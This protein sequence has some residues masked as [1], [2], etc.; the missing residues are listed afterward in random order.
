AR[1]DVDDLWLPAK[2]RTQLDYLKQNPQVALL[3]SAALRICDQGNLLPEPGRHPTTYQAIRLK[4]LLSNAFFHSS[5]LVNLNAL[6]EQKI[7]YD[8]AKT[9]AQDYDLWS[10]L[11]TQHQG[12]NLAQP[13]IKFRAYSGQLSTTAWEEQQSL[14]DVI[15]WENFQRMG[16][17]GRFTPSEVS[18]MRRTGVPPGQISPQDRLRQFRSLLRLFQL[19]G[20]LPGLPGQ[21]WI[22]FKR[23]LLFYSRRHLVAWPR[24]L[25]TLKT[26]TA[27]AAL[28]LPG[29]CRDIAAWLLQRIKGSGGKETSPTNVELGTNDK[30]LK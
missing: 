19:I 18:L 11:L 4:M 1:L 12:A 22:Q 6:S 27:M 26:Q 23:S 2:L 10:R 30:E 7:R 21:E 13:L 20:D 9:Y 3:G 14:G 24:D 5:V 15:A 17:N 29:A 28:D 8:P 25:A 16:L